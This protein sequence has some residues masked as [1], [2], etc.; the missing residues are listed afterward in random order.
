MSSAFTHYQ[1]PGS[2]PSDYA[3]RSH[4][5]NNEPRDGVSSDRDDTE[6]EG[7]S[8][9]T[10]SSLLRRTSLPSYQR[11]QN[12]TMVS[13]QS[14]HFRHIPV[15]GPIPSE[16]TPLLNPPVPRIDEPLDRTLEKGNT[17]KIFWEELEILARY[18][19][20]VFGFV[21]MYCHLISTLNE[22]VS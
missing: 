9:R 2:L 4:R 17:M 22:N 14:H 15:P 18:A 11:S 12:P 7:M 16:N 5:P 20:P 6:T 1:Q 3:I 8:G 13:A 21:F 10:T 19:A